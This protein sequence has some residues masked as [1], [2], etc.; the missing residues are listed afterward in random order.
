MTANKKTPTDSPQADEA[1]VQLLLARRQA[2]AEELHG[3]TSRAE[4][5]RLLADVFAADQ[6]TQMAL[7]KTLARTRD[8]DA[9]DLLLAAHELAPLKEVRKEARRGLIQLAGARSIPVG[10]PSLSPPL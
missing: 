8:S 6:A 10:P 7:L 9:A 1:R 4:A 2:F 3:C 5:Q